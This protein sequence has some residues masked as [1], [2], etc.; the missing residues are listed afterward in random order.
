M[1]QCRHKQGQ[2]SQNADAE[3]HANAFRPLRAGSQRHVVAFRAHDAGCNVQGAIRR[4]CRPSI[5]T[6]ANRCLA[7]SLNSCASKTM[8]RTKRKRFAS[9]LTTTR[10]Q[11]FEAAFLALDFV[12]CR[13]ARSTVLVD[14]LKALHHTFGWQLIWTKAS[15]MRELGTFVPFDASTQAN[16]DKQTADNNRQ[17]TDKQTDKQTDTQTKQRRF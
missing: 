1:R 7:P 5:A 17:Q 10:W 9:R 2:Q 4:V 11:E 13:S 16:A 12:N 14:A 8:R 3:P 15:S 6:G